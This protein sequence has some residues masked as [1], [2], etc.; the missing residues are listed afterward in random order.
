MYLSS[1]VIN[2]IICI[3]TIATAMAIINPNK[4]F[5]SYFIL[6]QIQYFVIYSIKYESNANYLNSSSIIL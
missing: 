6:K 3:N 5:L 1:L 2:N 4:S